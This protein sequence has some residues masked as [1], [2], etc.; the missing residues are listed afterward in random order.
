MN[1]NVEAITNGI[2]NLQFDNS[3]ATTT[4][5]VTGSGNGGD[6]GSAPGV[7]NSNRQSLNDDVAAI[8]NGVGKL[9]CGPTF[10]EMA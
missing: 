8:T 7:D 9:R 6:G 10:S 2:K 3:N 5:T 4:A 1:Q